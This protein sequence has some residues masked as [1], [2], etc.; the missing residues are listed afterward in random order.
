MQWHLSRT[1]PTHPAVKLTH[2]LAPV[3]VA[4]AAIALLSV[5]DGAMKG[6]ALALGAYSAML[7]RALM[8]SAITLRSESVV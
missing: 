4:V 6:A 7:W 3:L 8:S 5:M 1:S 2:P